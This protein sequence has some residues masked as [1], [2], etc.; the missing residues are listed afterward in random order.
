MARF[1]SRLVAA[2][3]KLRQ[4]RYRSAKNGPYT[5]GRARGAALPLNDETKSPTWP[6][7][8][9][10]ARVLGRRLAHRKHNGPSQ[11][12][13]GFLDLANLA[14]VQAMCISVGSPSERGLDF[15]LV[16]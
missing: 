2:D 16:L 13:E 11:A 6:L 3:V 8:P 9:G 1:L 12:G 5:P 14:K 4:E 10:R 7:W 15:S